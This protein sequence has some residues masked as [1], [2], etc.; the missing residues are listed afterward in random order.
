MI[1]LISSINSPTP[2]IFDP[3]LYQSKDKFLPKNHSFYTDF[4]Y[5]FELT[6]DRKLF[7]S[8]IVYEMVFNKIN[9]DAKIFMSN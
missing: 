8:D 3:S 6:F 7:F 2:N 1:I 4:K 5:W 9:K